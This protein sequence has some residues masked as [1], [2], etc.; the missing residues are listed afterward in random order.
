MTTPPKVSI[1]IPVYNG[2]DYLREAIDSALAQTYPSIEIVVVNDGSRDD[3]TTEQ[4]ALSYGDRIRYF[5]KENGGV[6][7]ALN[8]GIAEMN[9]NYFSWLS[10]D[11]LYS[12]NKISTQMDALTELGFP[13]A[14][15]YSDWSS[16]SDNP[17]QVQEVRMPPVRPEQFRYFLTTTN[18]LHGCTLLIPRRAFA[19]CGIF[20]E[21]LQT[22]Q[23]YDLWFRMAGKFH[24]LQ[25]PGVLVKGRR[26]DAQ[27]SV[28]MK[29]TALKEINTL[30]SGFTKK[31]THTELTSTE[32]NSACL[33][34]AEIAASFWRRYFYAAAREVTWMAVVSWHNA[35]LRAGAMSSFILFRAVANTG[36][37][38]WTRWCVS[39]P[40]RFSLRIKRQ[41]G[42]LKLRLLHLRTLNLQQKFSLIYTDNIWGGIE[43]RS[44]TG[45]D[46]KQ[47]Q[48]IRRQLPT[49]IDELDIQTM[50]DAPCGDLFWMQ[51]MQL[52]VKKYIG[53]DI[54]E[55]LIENNR[56]EFGDEIREFLCLNLAQDEL[57]SVDLIFCRDCLV[58]LNFKDLQNVL[59]NFKR[60]GSRYLLTTTFPERDT[61]IDLLGKNIWRAL[62]L[63]EAPFNFPAPLRLINEKCSE[64][65]GAHAD[66]SLGLW[67]LSDI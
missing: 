58:H 29:H 47:T 6:A 23:D 55:S 63:Q 51:T 19:V 22:T 10:H 7:S 53:V 14:V 60:S 32:H 21:T 37:R 16:F 61:N 45:S 34:Y 18:V 31:L 20:D 57:P 4:I 40:N 2:S 59:D 25:V 67:R 42:S 30:V 64:E 35:S 44:G 52:G 39:L 54:V 48:E 38:L 41:L 46:L 28:T 50:L 56:H 15:L 12:P 24:F 9:G 1:I 62:N 8:R 33:A 27:G 11:D 66:K 26:H 49:L 17:D 36:L 43:S 65:H 5:S 13:D 3:G